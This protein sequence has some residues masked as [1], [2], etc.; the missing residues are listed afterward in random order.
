M[1][2]RYV[3]PLRILVQFC[4]LAFMIW[5]GVRFYQFVLFFRSG[6]SS[7]FVERPAGVEG[8]LPISGLMGLSA[9][10][11][12]M[13]IN[14]IH[15]AAVVILLAVLAVSLLLRRSFCSWICPVA[16]ISEC[17]WKAG[18]GLF[19]RNPRAPRWLDVALRGLKYLLLA[20]F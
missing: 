1:P 3:Q 6:G 14:P 4:F 20:F 15:P 5:L 11:K 18:F 2:A 7:H 13:G 17:S 16:V 19:K 9:W 10:F 8:F 12:G